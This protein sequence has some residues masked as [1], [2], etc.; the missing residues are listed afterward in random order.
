MNKK[1]PAFPQTPP[2]RQQERR[3]EQARN[4]EMFIRTTR[5]EMTPML[6]DMEIIVDNS[7][8]NS[9]AAHC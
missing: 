3:M 4:I 7:V 1:S 5:E 8:A 9:H 2:G 6:A